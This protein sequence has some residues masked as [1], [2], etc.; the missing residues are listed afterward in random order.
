MFPSGALTEQLTKN[1]SDLLPKN[2]SELEMKKK[3]KGK[4]ERL[5]KDKATEVQVCLAWYKLLWKL[6]TDETNRI[7]FCKNIVESHQIWAVK[8]Q[9]P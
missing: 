5:L 4:T 8:R 3:K 7:I 9:F 1:K 6:R 2:V